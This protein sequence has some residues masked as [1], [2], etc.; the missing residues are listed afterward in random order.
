MHTRRR[1]ILAAVPVAL[2]LPA[3]AAAPA[4][5]ET[6]W[7][8]GG[9]ATIRLA[10][11][12]EAV[13]LAPVWSRLEVLN[14]CWNAWKPG[15]LGPLNE[16]LA[17]GRWATVTPAL[18]QA[19]MGAARLEAASLGHFNPAIG[20]L[21]RR[22]GFHAD[23]LRPGRGPSAAARRR[24]PG[25]R[26]SLSQLQWQGLHV[27]STN[28][29]LQID[30]GAY[31]KGLAAD[32]ALSQLMALGVRGA[33]V[34]LGGNLALRGD[35]G[36]R[37]WQVGLRDPEREGLL[38]Q[39]AAGP[40][41]AVVTS[42]SYERFRVVD[43]EVCCHLL[44]PFTGEPARELVSATVAHPDAARADAAATALMVAG[45]ARWRVVA[46]RLGLDQV[47]VVHRSGLAEMTPRLASRVQLASVWRASVRV[48]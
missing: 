24:W 22:W 48:I 2:V 23:E 19:I 16:A 12:A 11:G 10:D 32:L 18:R 37:P 42:G 17:Q 29:E 39:L 1:T 3:A 20:A 27:R 25:A 14:R 7:L 41:E 21:V 6:R 31:A 45:P 26:P 47:L 15:G 36:R 9:P 46:S 5:R 8:F 43:G 40:R 35:A 30:L 13:D 4:R 28:P 38:G 44:D 33:V 34:D